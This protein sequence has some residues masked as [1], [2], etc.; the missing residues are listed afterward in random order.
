MPAVSLERDE[1]GREI[2]KPG[3]QTSASAAAPMDSGGVFVASRSFSDADEVREAVKEAETNFTQVSSGKYAGGLTRVELGDLGMHHVR[4]EPDTVNVSFLDREHFALVMPFRWSGQLVW[5]GKE[6]HR[7]PLLLYAPGSEHMRRGRAV[8]GVA[9]AL[10]REWVETSVASLIGVDK[11]AAAFR[12]GEVPVSPR[13]RDRLTALLLQSIRAASANPEALRSAWAREIAVAQI[14]QAVLEIV[15]GAADL[16][17]ERGTRAAPLRIVRAADEHFEQA[18]DHIVSLP[19]LCRAA[20]VSARTLEY[21]FQQVC[22]LSPTQF[23]KRR[24]LS[25][26]RRKLLDSD[27]SAGAVKVAALDAGFLHL[28]RFSVEYRASF[29]ESPSETLK[30]SA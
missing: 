18:R 16:D 4:S 10:P 15:P 12:S 7:P 30:R 1:S 13:D 22:G 6:L 5:D 26:A 17:R 25:L 9:L 29:G 19:D 28:G 20:R 2:I 11:G 3:A 23:F 27:P 14:K 8:E 24:R 21:A